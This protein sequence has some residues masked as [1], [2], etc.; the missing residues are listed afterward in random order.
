MIVNKSRAQWHASLMKIPIKIDEIEKIP[1]ISEEIKAKLKS[2]QKVFLQ[3]GAP[4]CH[5]SRV[6]GSLGDLTIGCNLIAMVCLCIFSLYF[7]Y[8]KNVNSFLT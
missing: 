1:L 5:L 2:N 8:H 3:R 7:L 4:F 6:E